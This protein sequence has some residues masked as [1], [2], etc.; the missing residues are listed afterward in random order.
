[1]I[2]SVISS[3]VVLSFM[4]AITCITHYIINPYFV[5]IASTF[6][7]TTDMSIIIYLVSWLVSFIPALILL[8]F[9]M[10]FVQ[11]IR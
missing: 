8:V 9:I 7:N 5:D 11:K 4:I 3:I 2:I 1:M 6:N 10:A